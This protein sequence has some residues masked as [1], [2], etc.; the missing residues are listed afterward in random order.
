LRIACGA[1]ARITP[2]D[3]LRAEQLRAGSF[4]RREEIDETLYILRMEKLA[5]TVDVE[6]KSRTGVERDY[7]LVDRARLPPEFSKAPLVYLH[8]KEPVIRES[9]ADS[10]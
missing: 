5:S 2:A 3:G 7:D 9:F 1:D 10:R 6:G 8:L 4:S